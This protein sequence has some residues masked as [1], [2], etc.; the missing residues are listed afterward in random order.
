MRKNQVCKGNSQWCKPLDHWDKNYATNEEKEIAST[1]Y[2][3]S[4]LVRLG[5]EN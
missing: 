2:N 3:K 4:D 1:F 5:L